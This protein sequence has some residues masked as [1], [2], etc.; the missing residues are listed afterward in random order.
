MKNPGSFSG[1]GVS[2]FLGHQERRPS[3]QQF[4]P[5]RLGYCEPHG[6]AHCDGPTAIETWV[7]IPRGHKFSHKRILQ[8]FR[9]TGTN[10]LI[11]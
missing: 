4:A 2:S 7:P 11:P 9:I 1:S 3:F 10:A 5:S 8:D 6:S